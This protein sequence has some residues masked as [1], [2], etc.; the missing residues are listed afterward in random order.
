MFGC[1]L[2]A[3]IFRLA[4]MEPAIGIVGNITA[5]RRD[6]TMYPLIQKGGQTPPVKAV[7]RPR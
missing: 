2:Y 3:L 4:A 6:G 7:G 5:N 1:A